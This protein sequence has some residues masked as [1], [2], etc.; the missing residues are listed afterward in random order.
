MSHDRAV[1]R[2]RR[3]AARSSSRHGG[4]REYVG[5]YAD[6]LR[7][8]PKPATLEPEKAPRRIPKGSAATKRVAKADARLLEE[9]PA[10]I[11]GL[12]GEIAA[13][14]DVMASPDFFRQSGDR[15]AAEKK[16]LQDLEARL[17]ASYERWEELSSREDAAR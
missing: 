1:P 3:H 13:L 11:E 12:E 10:R 5:G 9:M 15:I 14:H 2:Q 17:A 8:R 4:V 16:R 6:W 7:Q